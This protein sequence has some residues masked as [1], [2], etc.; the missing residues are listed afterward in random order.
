MKKALLAAIVACT[1]YV[2]AVEAQDSFP[3]TIEFKPVSV[4]GLPGLHSYAYGQ[5]NGKWL[6]IGGRTDGLHPRQPF[7]SFPQSQNNTNIYVVDVQAG[8]SW[9]APVSSLPTSIAEQ[10]Q[11]TNMNFNQVDD[12]LYIMGGYAYSTTAGD[13]ITFPNLT[14]IQVS[15][16]IQA[17][18]N[19]SSFTSYFKQ[20]SDTAF[21]VSGGHLVSLNDTFYLVGGHKFT[22]RYNP[23]G[24]PTYTQSYTNQVRKMTINN[25][26]TQPAIANYSTITDPV[27]LHR[28]DYNL[29]PQVFPDRSEGFTI[30]SGVFQTTA[31]LPFLYPVD[32]KPSG[33]TPN[34]SFNQYLSNYHS[35]T[36]ALYDSS[37]NAMHNLFFGGISQYYYQNGTLVKDDNVPFVS[38]IS[39]LSRSANG[40]LKEYKLPVDMPGLKGS[41]AEFILNDAIDAYL[42][43]VIKMNSFNKDTILIGHILGGITSSAINPFSNNQTNLTAA[44]KT[45]YEVRLVHDPNASVEA[46]DG[47]HTYKVEAYPNPAQQAVN[48]R[49]NNAHFDYADY[50]LAAVD[51]RI[52]QQG[53]FTSGDMRNNSYNLHLSREIAPQ[54]LSLTVAFDNVYFV[55]LQIMKQ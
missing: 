52:L 35:A 49:I 14:T 9:S 6:I 39:R 12:T 15:S 36:A 44:D 24:N 48:L 11:A 25:S 54:V 27:H 50:Y 34:T 30:S 29:L 42:S 20:T 13:H 2:P 53:T 26:G 21:Q 33:I 22:G 41:S 19:N 7:N 17:I 16:V 51:G 38:T 3:Y 5:S 18:I 47:N 1:L 43:G 45:V 40:T 31:D 28:R 37:A 8:Q 32:V 10:M 55:T 23:M 46:L 4:T